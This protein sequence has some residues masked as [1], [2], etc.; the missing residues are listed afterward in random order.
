MPTPTGDEPR[1]SIFIF[2]VIQS[3]PLFGRNKGGLRR[4]DFHSR[5]LGNLAYDYSRDSDIVIGAIVSQGTN[6]DSRRLLEAD[7][8]F[9]WFAA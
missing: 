7:P 2:V 1:I 5:Q 4:L 8:R 3:L 9:L 6:R